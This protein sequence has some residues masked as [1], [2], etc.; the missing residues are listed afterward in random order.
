LSVLQKATLVHFSELTS[1]RFAPV[2]PGRYRFVSSHDVADVELRE[3]RDRPKALTSVQKVPSWSDHDR[4]LAT[5]AYD[6]L[7]RPNRSG[8]PPGSAVDVRV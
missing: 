2:R 1:V 3:V 4:R 7:G 6:R 8:P 5:E